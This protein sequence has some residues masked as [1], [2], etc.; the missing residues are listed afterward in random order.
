[1][2]RVSSKHTVSGD[3]YESFI[4]ESFVDVCLSSCRLVEPVSSK[5]HAKTNLLLK[6]FHCQPSGAQ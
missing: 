2:V 1:M 5:G 6:I 3:D 4:K